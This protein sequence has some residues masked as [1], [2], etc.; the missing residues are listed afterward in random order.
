MKGPPPKDP[1]RRARRNAAPPIVD[2]PAGGKP[3]RRRPMPPHAEPPIIAK[4][5]E[6]LVDGTITPEDFDARLT[7]LRHLRTWHPSTRAWW[8]TWCDSAQ[9]S[10]FSSTDWQRLEM[11]AYL[12]DRYFRAPAKDLLAEIRLNEAAIGATVED[13]LKLRWR[14]QPP[15][16]PNEPAP[17]P[18]SRSRADPRR[19]QLVRPQP[20]EP[21]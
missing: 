3:P 1:E 16:D 13:R 6:Q 11:V 5:R 17:P 20:K 4:L 2:L 21:A 10:E 14:L 19:L 8:R 18:G 15:P 12:V 9:S 7:R